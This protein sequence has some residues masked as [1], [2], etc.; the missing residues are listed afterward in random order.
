MPME[1]QG[2]SR[3]VAAVDKLKVKLK[4]YDST[5]ENNTTVLASFI[6]KNLRL[7]PCI[8]LKKI[9]WN[10]NRI[11][12]RTE[13]MNEHFAQTPDLQKK[14]CLNNIYQ[15]PSDIFFSIYIVIRSLHW[16][17]EILFVEVNS[18][19]RFAYKSMNVLSPILF[20]RVW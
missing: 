18:Q 10:P 3:S 8:W 13:R 15:A 12:R 4:D 7:W 5:V 6:V 14:S 20:T 1:G 19:R 16:Y 17:V 2:R 11:I 9:F